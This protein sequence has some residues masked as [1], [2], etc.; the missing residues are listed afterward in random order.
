MKRKLKQN[1]VIP[2]L[3]GIT[4]GTIAV[5]IFLLKEIVFF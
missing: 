4:L 5:A 1:I 3:T 2:M